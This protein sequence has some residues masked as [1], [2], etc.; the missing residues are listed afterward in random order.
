M[1]VFAQTCLM[2]LCVSD[3]PEESEEEDS[4]KDEEQSE[5]DEEDEEEEG[6]DE[7]SCGDEGMEVLL[8]RETTA[9]RPPAPGPRRRSATL[10]LLPRACNPK[11]TRW[12]PLRWV[13]VTRI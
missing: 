4:E 6:S 7:D 2:F 12:P 13:P 5:E 1:E 9:L 8:K 11:A 3:S 10:L